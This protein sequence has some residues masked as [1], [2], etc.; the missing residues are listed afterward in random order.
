MAP[1]PAL[2]SLDDLVSQSDAAEHLGWSV[3]TVRRRIADGTLPGYRVGP[4]SIRI[5]R[6][7]L[8]ALLRPI[9]SAG[10]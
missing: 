5:R 3:R 2:L 1:S 10:E 6:A 9:P 8:D 7:D 4:T